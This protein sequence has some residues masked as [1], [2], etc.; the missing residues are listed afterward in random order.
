MSTVPI[1]PNEPVDE[2]TR[3][4]LDERLKTIDHDAKSARPWREVI[5]ESQSKL[6]HPD[7]Q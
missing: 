6:K 1:R 2:E 7:P 4:I 5:A 3:T